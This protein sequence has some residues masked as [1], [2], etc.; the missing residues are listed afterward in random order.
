MLRPTLGIVGLVLMGFLLCFCSVEGSQKGKKPKKPEQKVV[1]AIW[2]WKLIEKREVV[3]EGK[4]RAHKG[5]LYGMAGSKQIGMYQEAPSKEEALVVV[6]SGPLTGKFL[7]RKVTL[8][9]PH[10]EG[11]LL[12]PDGTKIRISVDLLAD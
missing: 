4:F 11:F 9:P 8:K 10:Y 12:K 2:H 1:G 3:K 6:E 5:C 7:L